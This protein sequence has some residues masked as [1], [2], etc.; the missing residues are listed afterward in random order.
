MQTNDTF[1]MFAWWAVKSEIINSLKSMHTPF[2]TC[3]KG[4]EGKSICLIE[5]LSVGSVF[6]AFYFCIYYTPTE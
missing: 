5:A 1:R 4:L 3:I 6:A 2:G